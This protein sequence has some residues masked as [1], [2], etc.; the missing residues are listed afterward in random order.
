MILL[1]AVIDSEIE[2]AAEEKQAAESSSC[3]AESQSENKQG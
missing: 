3:P 1:G 2:A